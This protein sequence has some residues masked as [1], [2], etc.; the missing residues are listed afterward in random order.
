MF[1]RFFT[2]MLTVMILALSAHA[3]HAAAGTIEDTSAHVPAGLRK[4]GDLDKSW[5]SACPEN[6]HGPQMPISEALASRG[7]FHAERTG[8]EP[9]EELITPHRFSKPAHSTT[10]PPLQ[11]GFSESLNYRLLFY[12]IAV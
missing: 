3:V 1:V 8:F 4:D 12:W 9:V 5:T 7:S 2:T 11:R 10:L 6:E